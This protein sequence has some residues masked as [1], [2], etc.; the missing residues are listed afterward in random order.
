MIKREKKTMEEN[1]LIPEVQDGTEEVA[2]VS[3]RP[4]ILNEY[5]E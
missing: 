5:I 1:L 4:K 2:E 3:L